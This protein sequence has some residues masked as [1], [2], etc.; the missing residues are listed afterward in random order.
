[1]KS[2]RFEIE[3]K[4]RKAT[5]TTQF[6]KGTEIFRFE[7][8]DDGSLD[9]LYLVFKDMIPVWESHTALERKDIRA[10]GYLIEEKTK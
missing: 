6:D 4:G 9:F 3:Y 5:V 8:E 2:G 7:C 10:L 1:M